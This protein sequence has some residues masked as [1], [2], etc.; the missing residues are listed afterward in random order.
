M[1]EYAISVGRSRTEKK[2]KTKQITLEAFIQRLGDPV[3][4]AE[5]MAEYA[6]Y[7]KDDRDAR[8]DV[9]GYVAAALKD[10]RRANGCVQWR[11]MVTLDLDNVDASEAD[12]LELI[13]RRCPYY[14]VVHPTHSHRPE[15]PRLRLIV[16]LEAAITEEQYEPIARRVAADINM[17]WFDPTTFQATRLMY[18]PSVPCDL[19]YEAVFTVHEGPLCVGADMLARYTDWKNI[20][21]WPVTSNEIKLE[22]HRA[23]TQQDPRE[24]NNEVGVFCRAYTIQEAIETFL[25]DVYTPTDKPNRYTYAAGST[26]GGLVLYDD[27]FAYDNHATSPASG[28]LCNAFDLVRIHKFGEEDARSRVKDPTKLPSYKA[29]LDLIADDD[30]INKQA[31]QDLI[32]RQAKVEDEFNFDMVP[33]DQR[34]DSWKE[35]LKY[36][37]NGV[38]AKTINNVFLVLTH[39]PAFKGKLYTDT[40]A[41]RDVTEDSLPWSRKYEDKDKDGKPKKHYRDWSDADTAQLRRYLENYYDGLT[42]K[43]VVE[44]GLTNAFQAQSRHPV[45]EYL[46]SLPE[47]D[48]NHRVDTLLADYLGAE[49]SDFVRT[50]TRT[51][52]VA[53]VARVM[54]PGVK[55]DTMIVLCGSQ[56]AHKSSFI[57][58]L[59]GDDWFND[60][61]K[62]F[63]GDKDAFM[64]IQGSWMVE[65]AEMSA[66]GKSKSVEFKS[67][68]SKTSDIFRA[69]YGHRTGRQ[70]RQCI[71]WGTTN[72]VQFLKDPTGERR[73]WP[74]DVSDKDGITRTKNVFEDLAG[75]RDQIWAEALQYYRDGHPLFLNDEMER[76]AESV[77]AVFTEEDDRKDSIIAFLEKGI[78]DNWK[79]M[80][81]SDRRDWLSGDESIFNAGTPVPRTT[82]TAFEIWVECF[83]KNVNEPF[84]KSD[85]VF[86]TDIMNNLP[87]WETVRGSIKLDRK[88]YDRKQKRVYFIRKDR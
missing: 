27:I 74:V 55:Y 72:S 32:A 7:S 29:M 12:A 51:H 83:N 87:G 67:F 20:G 41:A 18:W 49:D 40:F 19:D 23:K 5:T 66:Y 52:L 13:A 54:E 46:E 81:L 42:N 10:S 75:E 63:S 24:K 68:M 79:D 60:S 47:W 64:L 80:D 84:P 71:F 9:G 85:N 61:L 62:D 21:E 37:K 22:E 6:A 50:I 53:A 15:T 43:D 35:L 56:G 73:V 77:R 2:W 3:V 78:T 28:Q 82:V 26:V 16:P 38:V 76:T 25:P 34:D 57:R 30:R 44:T 31:A 14:Y 33:E 48:G 17:D 65:A 1:Q 4:T 8:K 88:V 70:P 69:P 36:D 45:R 39:D 58:I 59:C 11:S 86:I